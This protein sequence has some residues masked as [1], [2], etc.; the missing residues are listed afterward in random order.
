MGQRWVASMRRG[1]GRNRI[2]ACGAILVALLV[3]AALLAPAIAPFDPI[4]LTPR[5]RL[6]PPSA[7]HW[8]GTDEGGRDI[9]SRILFGARYSLLA[10]VVVL[11]LAV[12]VG[13]TIGL[14]AGFAGG[15]VDEALM[16]ITDMFLAFPG[17]VLAM[18]VVAAVQQRGLWVVIVAIS[19]RWWAPYARMMRAQVLGLRQTD[20]VEAARAL[21]ASARR[22]M[23][24]HILPNAISPIIVQATL[25]LGYIIL[26]AASLS[27]I[28]FGAQPGEPDWGRMVADGRQYM[29]DYWWIV[30][31]PGLAIFLSVM[32]FNLVGDAARDIFD[33]RLHGG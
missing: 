2:A 15:K 13:S 31:F 4:A 32:A 25:D 23:F 3:L 9:L 5:D 14:I 16:R 6:L 30:T 29:R 1:V 12:T 26:T 27:F 18:A 20:Y 19:I 33:P 21:G 7:S 8:F 17:L 28:G 11:A 10:A 22:T 24:A